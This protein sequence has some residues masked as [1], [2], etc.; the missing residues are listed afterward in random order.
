MASN[1][2]III[3]ILVICFTLVKCKTC[4]KQAFYT[5][6]GQ[7][8]RLKPIYSPMA[9]TVKQCRRMCRLESS[10]LSFNFI[11]NTTEDGTCELF[12]EVDWSLVDENVFDAEY[13]GNH[14]FK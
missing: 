7:Q 5:M 14:C 6:V 9:T 2:E 11:K 12:S 4:T 3:F 13:H 10:C 8:K 1:L